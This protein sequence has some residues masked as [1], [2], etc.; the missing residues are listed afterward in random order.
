MARSDG[1]TPKSPQ[2]N[3]LPDHDKTA[4][5]TPDLSYTDKVFVAA[6]T[7]PD[8]DTYG[9]ARQSYARAHPNASIETAGA[10]GSKKLNNTSVRAYIEQTL[11]EI[12]AGRQVRLAALQRVIQGTH[13]KTVRTTGTRVGEDG[14]PQE[15]ETTVESTPSASEIIKA[16]DLVNKMTGLYDANRES[17]TAAR[18]EYMKMRRE[19]GKRGDRGKGKS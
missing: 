14:S 13:V 6:Y 18:Q 3:T 7:D 10:N 2:N 8:S 19:Q 12:G 16:I 11:E 9:N 15:Y 1:E 4:A 5:K 17:A